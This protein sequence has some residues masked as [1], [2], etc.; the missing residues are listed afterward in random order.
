MALRNVVTEEDPILRKRSREVAEVTPRI[1][2]LVEDLWETMY[3]K[4]GVG[5][6]A[7]QVGVLRRVVVI[8]ATPREEDAEDG[9]SGGVVSDGLSSTQDRR[10]GF[11]PPAEEEPPAEPQKYA[12]I[13]PEIVWRSEETA[14]EQ[15]GCLSVPGYA[16]KVTRPL[17][18]RV[19]A[20]DADG[21][22]IEV[23]GEGLL[24]RALCHEIDHLEGV[25]Y[26]DIAEEVKPVGQ[27]AEEEGEEAEA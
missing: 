5:L 27:A 25:L 3:E 19:K 14:C 7:P 16:G 26:T 23:E 10:G 12:L 20:L 2:E 15:E 1:R 24:A 21:R 17:K 13:N 8:D 11:Q 22:A 4:D 6:A 18:V 9:D